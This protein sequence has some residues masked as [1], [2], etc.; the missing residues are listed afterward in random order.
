MV[1][2]GSLSVSADLGSLTPGKDYRL[3]WSVARPENDGTRDRQNGVSVEGSFTF[4]A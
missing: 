3:Q 4:T 2:G 1:V